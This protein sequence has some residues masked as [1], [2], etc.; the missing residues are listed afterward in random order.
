MFAKK[1]DFVEIRS[2]NISTVAA[3]Q[4]NI[5]LGMTT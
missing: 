5:E 1:P 4:P 3:L 2:Q